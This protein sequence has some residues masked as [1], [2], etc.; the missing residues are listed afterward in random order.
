MLSSIDYAA[1]LQ[2]SPRGS[3]DVSVRSRRARDIIKRGDKSALEDLAKR[4]AVMVDEGEFENWFGGEATLIP[5]PRSAPLKDK[6]ALWTP[7]R[8]CEALNAEGIGSEVA[9]C[10]ERMVAVKK[11]A[12]QAPGERTTVQEHYDSFGVSQDIFAPKQT[13]ILVDDFVT[14]GRTLCA[15]TSKIADAFPGHDV[16]GFAMVRTVGFGEVDTLINPF[17]G[18]I[19]YANGDAN[20]GD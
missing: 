7:K 20:R 15:A 12:Y 3:S 16:R 13:I 11:S 18:V 4:I 5:V 10:L 17:E 19:N 2:Y 8:I 9:T 6:D 14:R 1:F